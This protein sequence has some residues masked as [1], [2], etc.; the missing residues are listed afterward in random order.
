MKDKILK[1]FVGLFQYKLIDK[2]HIKN[3]RILDKKSF[4]SIERIL[5]YLIKNKVIKSLI[6]VGANDGVRF[7]SLN[8]F[9]K[10]YKLSCLLVEPIKE[11]F[12]DLKK[13]Y[14]NL[15]NII[16]ENSSISVDN[17]ISHLYKVKKKFLD[18]YGNHVRGITSFRIEH[19]IHHGVKK[20]HITK[21]EVASLSIKEL[22]LKHKFEKFELL[23]ID[24]E[25]YD[26]K[27]VN[28]FLLN[29]SIRP[30]IIFEYIH[31]DHSTFKIVTDNLTKS[32]YLFFPVN[33]NLVCIPNEKRDISIFQPNL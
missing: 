16:F 7:D 19:L 18:I 1:K 13:N 24:V 25:G 3:N 11:H 22:L 29:N 4:I 32:K 12:E 8:A 30:Y 2:K 33:E 28:D 31:I 10:E 20:K 5:K 27:L 26:G 21:Q 9:I 17:E 23:F 15:D 14:A 6:Q